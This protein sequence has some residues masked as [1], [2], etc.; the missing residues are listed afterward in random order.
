MLKIMGFATRW[1]LG[2]GKLNLTGK[3]PNGQQFIANAQRVWLIDS[4]QAV[5]NGGDLGPTG[6]L[7]RQARL[8]E[9]LIPQ[10]GLFAVANA[11]LQT[12][13]TN[14]GYAKELS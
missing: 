13:R 5:L 4:S 7:T 2:T 6:A 12:P 14:T 9:F 10:R 3:T 8:N 1:A 11:F